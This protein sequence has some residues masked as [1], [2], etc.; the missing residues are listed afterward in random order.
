[1][2]VCADEKEEKFVLS[3]KDKIF[4]CLNNFGYKSAFVDNPDSAPNNNVYLELYL[5]G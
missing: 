1:M 5:M 4:E 3:Q 2:F